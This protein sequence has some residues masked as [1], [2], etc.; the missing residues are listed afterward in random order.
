MQRV[1]ALQ[2]ELP[3]EEPEAG[4]EGELH[5]AE[6]AQVAVPSWKCRPAS[7]TAQEPS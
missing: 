2:G 6:E 1:V 4:S 3:Q 5:Q 7:G